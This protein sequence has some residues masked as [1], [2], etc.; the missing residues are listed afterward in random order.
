M[1]QGK[2]IIS[3]SQGI[4]FTRIFVNPEPPIPEEKEWNLED[5][6]KAYDGMIF[7]LC[8]AFSHSDKI[9]YRLID[10]RGNDISSKAKNIKTNIFKNSIPL[11]QGQIESLSKKNSSLFKKTDVNIFRNIL[12]S[13]MPTPERR[14][15]KVIINTL[16]YFQ[17]H[18]EENKNKSFFEIL[19]KNAL[20]KKEDA[21][22]SIDHFL[23]FN[24]IRFNII[25]NIKWN[26]NFDFSK[27]YI[28]KD[29]GSIK[30][31][32]KKYNIFNNAVLLGPVVYE[33]N[34]YLGDVEIE[35]GDE[36]NGRCPTFKYV[37]TT[38]QNL[39]TAKEELNYME[40]ED[41]DEDEYEDEYED[42]DED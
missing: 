19:L 14:A 34:L 11:S 29:E 35:I 22:V 24:D 37:V 31:F 10:D 42:E 18:L 7:Y 28:L 16:Q 15:D 25:F 36:T 26:D 20:G 30:G 9:T 38:Y 21:F 39:Q 3:G 8:D 27:V 23:K 6:F 41:E 4:P 32:I 5:K 12:F 17:D 13:N 33:G 2:L 40:D 1:N